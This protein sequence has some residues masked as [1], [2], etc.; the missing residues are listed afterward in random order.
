V[1]QEPETSVQE[2]TISVG[3]YNPPY[4]AADP[5]SDSDSVLKRKANGESNGD[6][7]TPARIRV[8][9]AKLDKTHNGADS[10][11]VDDSLAS[12]DGQEAARRTVTFNEVY[13][14][15]PQR[16]ENG[17]LKLGPGYRHIIVQY[18]C[19][20]GG[21]Y[22]LRCDGHGVHFGEH[23]LRGAAKHLASAQHGH[24]SKAH[25]TAI[26]T[27]GHLVVDC[28]QELAE[29][30]N[31]AV[32]EAFKEGGYKPFNANNLS[33]TRRA[34]LG[35]PPLDSPSAQT[36]AAHRM[37]A[38]GGSQQGPSST[39]PARFRKQFA[40][41]V[42][43]ISCKFYLACRGELKISVLI[44]PW[45]D[46]SPAGIGGTL[47]DTGL[48]GDFTDDGK[49]LGIPKL[50]KCYIYDQVGGRISGIRGWA[51]GYESGP[52]VR[53]REFPVVCVD[54]PD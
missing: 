32:I 40:G 54:G 41:V 22:I 29:K 3:V 39:S 30:N 34:E 14:T 52:L 27:L 42:D 38:H 11:A 16:D 43:P 4:V 49:P 19:G 17:K 26:A 36:A 45:G 48:L 21:F 50:P 46:V 2:P 7:S 23:P 47:A 37:G 6:S 5:V 31:A 15:P 18:P 12:S 53:K 20:N 25:A 13:G 44:L 8:K 10:I 33:Q 35:F 9:R 1:G 28:T 51:S 24:M